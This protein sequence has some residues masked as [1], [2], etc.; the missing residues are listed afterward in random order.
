MEFIRVLI[1]GQSTLQVA[2]LINGQ[3][4]G[5]TGQVIH[6]GQSGLEIHFGRFADRQAAKREGEEDDIHLPDDYR[7]RS[8][9]TFSGDEQARANGAV[10]SPL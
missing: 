1:K 2:V 9:L 6:A 7:D 10:W 8:G 5:T 3:R 4:N